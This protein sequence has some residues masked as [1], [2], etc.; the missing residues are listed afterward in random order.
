V[1]RFAFDAFST[2]STSDK[3]GNLLTHVHILDLHE[4]G[5]IKPHVDAVR[6]CGNT[7]AGLSLLSDCVMKLTCEDDKNKW[8]K[9]LL[10]RR[11]L[12]IMRF[13]IQFKK[14]YKRIMFYNINFLYLKLRSIYS[15]KGHSAL[16]LRA[17]GFEAERVVFQRT[18]NSEEP[19]FVSYLPQ[20]AGSRAKH[21]IIFLI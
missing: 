7:I 17:W 14:P 8:A 4:D 19:S 12:Y 6:F 16:W 10:K 21:L 15:I 5:F 20:R 1:K 9:A 3:A 13:V 2:L 11:S 18:A